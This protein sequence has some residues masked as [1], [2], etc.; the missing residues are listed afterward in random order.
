MWPILYI[1][2][3]PQYTDFIYSILIVFSV[4]NDALSNPGVLCSI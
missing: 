1:K 4:N 3:G 2:K